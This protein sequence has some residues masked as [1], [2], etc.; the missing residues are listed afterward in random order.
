MATHRFLLSTPLLR[1]ASVSYATPAPAELKDWL[2]IAP[3]QNI[4]RLQTAQREREGLA[5]F[6]QL[7]TLTI[8]RTLDRQ[9]VVSCRLRS[10][11]AIIDRPGRLSGVDADGTVFPLNAMPT[12]ERPHLVGTPASEQLRALAALLAQLEKR[13][14]DFYSIVREIETDRM[15]PVRFVFM[16]GAVALWGDMGPETALEKAAN[17]LRLFEHFVPARAPATFRFITPDRLVIDANWTDV[18]SK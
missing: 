10:P 15:L 16:N 5:K 14:P 17:T 8:E 2:G 4:V 1:V 7:S 11:V 9:I 18:K 12:P 13:A 3:G 6:P